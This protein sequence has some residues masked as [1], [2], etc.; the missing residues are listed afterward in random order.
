MFTRVFHMSGKLRLVAVGLTAVIVVLTAGLV[1]LNARTVHGSGTG[2]G[3]CFP[4]TGPACHF[5][6]DNASVD[7]SSVS[8][9]GCIFTDAT[10]QPFAS[11][12]RP[13]GT[14]TQTV[15][16]F[17]SKW[18]NCQ[19]QGGCSSVNSGT[20]GGGGG[21]CGVLLEEATNFDPITGMPVFNGTIQFGPKLGTA[22]V[23]GSAPMTDFVTGAQFT[24]TVN[25]SW[26]GYGPT[27]TF[28]DSFSDRQPGFMMKSHTTGSSRSAEAS[29]VITDETGSNLAA[30]ST[31][32]ASLS[33]SKGG[34]VQFRRF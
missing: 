3:G 15:I 1:F 10:V 29:G 11:L 14:A 2:G 16:I 26:K 27:S 8:K 7:F 18:D 30:S 9:D 17:I 4:S 25:V 33:D 6:S 23:N 24:S 32:N 22:A 34:T 5:A 20:G 21:G 31:A 19:N 12:T 13:G 28:M